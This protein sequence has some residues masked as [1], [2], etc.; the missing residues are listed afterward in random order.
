VS[1]NTERS[2]LKIW[3][4]VIIGSLLGDGSIQRNHKRWIFSEEHTEKQKEYIV[5]KSRMIPGSRYTEYERDFG[6]VCRLRTISDEYYLKLRNEWYP[7]GKKIVPKS[8]LKNLDEIALTVWYL[9]DGDNAGSKKQ[10]K[11]L[12]G[13]THRNTARIATHSFT[14]KENL[15]LRRALHKNFGIVVNIT[16]DREYYRMYFPSKTK[17]VDKLMEIA[18]KTFIELDIPE[19][20]KYK[21]GERVESRRGITQRI[22]L[23]QGIIP[24]KNGRFVSKRCAPPQI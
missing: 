1:D 21:I 12:D 20:M 15:L 17:A 9:D 10:M 5:W 4:S 16:K 11:Y 7:N 14:Y 6:K 24:R 13:L 19:S 22:L 3:Q 8:I 2:P 18:K 23:E